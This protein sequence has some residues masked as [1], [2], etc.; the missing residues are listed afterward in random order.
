MKKANFNMTLFGAIFFIV[1][2]LFVV[3]GGILFYKNI[4]FKKI[5]VEGQATI[6]DIYKQIDSD[7]ET[8][9]TVIVEYVVD[10]QRY[11]D[12]LDYYS[13]GMEIGENV[14]IYYDPNN[15]T[16]FSS[17]GVNIAFI[18]FIGLGGIFA[19][20]GA[21]FMIN[22]IKKKNIQKRI[23]ESNIVIQA[24]INSFDFNRSLSINGRH[25]Y[26]LIASAIAPYDGL[27]YTFESDSIWDDLTPILQN[28]NITTVP[29]Y[30][31]PQNYKEYYMDIDS[32]KKYLGN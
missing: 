13:A 17:D 2:L 11:E 32:F 20:M 29:V 27:I 21:V 16:K 23:R 26:I 10:G 3:V 24:N 15:P 30:V 4:E 8:S 22:S 18:I 12:S 14:K 31:N 7:G 1:G 19:I 6:V 5:A 9:Y 25:P 28:Y